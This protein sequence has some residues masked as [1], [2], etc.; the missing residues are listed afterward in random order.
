MPNHSPP[1]PTASAE[2]LGWRLGRVREERGLSVEQVAG[3]IHL[4]RHYVQALEAGKFSDLPG[5]AYVRGYLRRY[6]EFLELNV[7]EMLA[8]YDQLEPAPPRKFFMLSDTLERNPYPSARLVVM[9]LIALT[10]LFFIWAS[11]HTTTPVKLVEPYAP[12]E[13]QAHV[14]V[15]PHRCDRERDAYPPCFWEDLGL[16]Y[17][18]YQSDKH[19]FNPH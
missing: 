16:W 10:V 19:M 2:D 12:F 18:P 15:P 5:A 11:I 9:C 14:K 6:A 8:L 17:V 3:A 1:E 13:N 7:M 4:R